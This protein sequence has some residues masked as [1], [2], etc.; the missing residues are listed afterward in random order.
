[1]A[2]LFQID[3]VRYACSCGSL[4]SIA[5]IYFC[6][7]CL[8]IRCGYCVCHEVDSY[9][10]SNCLENPPAS[11]VRLKKYKCS[12]CFDCPCCFETL[13]IRSG[14]VLVKSLHTTQEES[15]PVTKKIYYLSCTLCRWSSRDAGIPDQTVATGSWREQESPNT[16]RITALINFY[17][18]LGSIEKQQ[19]ERK[20]FQSKRIFLQFEK[21]GITSTMARKRVGQLPLLQSNTQS[22]QPQPS[23]A[24][25]EIEELS[26]D[27]FTKSIDI[28]KITTLDQRLQHPELQ[29]ENINE[30]RPQRKQFIV[31]RSQRC[32]F[33]EHTVS[34][35]DYCPTSTKFKIQLAA[36]Y[37]VPELRIVACE[38][39]RL[40][41]S[42]EL[43]LKFCN[44]TQHQ[45]QIILLSMDT[46]MMP[47]T[48]T[49]QG[50]KEEIN[51][52]NVQMGCDSPNLLPSAVRQAIVVEEG[53]QVNIV[54]NAEV[55][56]PSSS[57]ILP[58]RD[59]A[60][61]YDDPSDSQNS[62]DDPK[63]VVWRKGNKAIIRLDVIPYV[64]KDKMVKDEPIVVGL[65]M[66]YGYINTIATLEHKAP[67]K[68]DLK[69]KLFL[70][71]G[72]LV[73]NIL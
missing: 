35:P 30:L 23:E 59:D 53:R 47:T 3:C 67:Q 11:E 64:D 65:A 43:L 51:R 57:F 62:Q 29:V 10:C 6:R 73:H 41:Y 25:E 8:S 63:L 38:P 20:K 36:F 5:K 44:P 40:G 54:I 21:F 61:E 4:K 66:Q 19:K 72:N 52:E 37:H 58:P 17:K 27:I 2:Y 7:H 13:S 9:Y 18:I 70:T 34:K 33:C 39:L 15:K 68:L 12:N 46:P 26:Q 24:S 71:L 14:Q 16:Y 56:L 1:M 60:A 48:T 49:L 28:T 22:D 31:K 42:S 45:T 55:I 32:R 69:V 50:I